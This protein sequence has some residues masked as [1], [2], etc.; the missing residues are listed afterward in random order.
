M[1]RILYFDAV[2]NMQK[3]MKINVGKT[4]PEVMK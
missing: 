2:P 1:D 4:V 3:Y